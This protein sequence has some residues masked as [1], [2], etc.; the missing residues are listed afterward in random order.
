MTSPVSDAPAQRRAKAELR[1]IVLELRDSGRLYPLHDAELDDL[2][3]G[4]MDRFCDIA[5]RLE[6]H[7][8]VLDIGSGHGMLLAVLAELGHECAGVD[9]AD[10]ANR[11]PFS[12]RDRAIPFAVSNAEVEPLPFRDA[13]FDAVTCCQVLEHF[14]HSH[15]PLMREVLRVLR[16]GG[17]LEVDVP[18]AVSFRNR[19]RMLRGKHITYDYREHYL[20]AEPIRYKGMSFFPAR[21]N[22]EFTRDDLRLLLQE[23]GFADIDVR[24]LKSRRY[25]TGLDR[26]RSLGTAL[27]DTVPSLRKSLIAFAVKP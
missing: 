23:A 4:S 1:R 15:L 2:F 16:P 26:V 5:E 12:Y 20:H 25:R 22:R 7:R 24:F 6:G 3:R 18:N 10:Q 19:S 11:Y 21:H 8:R 17:V 14:S 13:S 27:K 9:F